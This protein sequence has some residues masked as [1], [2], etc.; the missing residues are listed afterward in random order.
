MTAWNKLVKKSYLLQHNLLF[1][2]GML[3]E[4]EIWN[5]LN[6]KYITSCAF[7]PKNT[8]TYNVRANSI[9]ANES[10]HR[11]WDRHACIWYVMAKNIGGYRKDIQIRGLCSFIFQNTQLRYPRFIHIRLF[12]ILA[13]LACKASPKMAILLFA[14]SIFALLYHHKYFNDKIRLRLE[15][16]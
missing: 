2:E 9:T 7:V 15:L 13:C 10:E 16:N 6:A 5:F 14:Q 8:Y 4:D 11:F 1:T 12:K 3:S